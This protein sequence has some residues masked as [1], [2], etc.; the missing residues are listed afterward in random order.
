MPALVGRHNSSNNDDNSD[1]DNN[2]DRI[3]DNAG[4][5]EVIV[6]GRRDAKGWEKIPET[7]IYVGCRI[8]HIHYTPLNGDG[9]F[10]YVRMSDEE[11]KELIN[12][13]DNLRYHRVHKWALLKVGEE[14]YWEWIVV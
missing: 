2:A 9:E 3:K 6:V 7:N 4:D 5:K 13:N 1:H 11:L 14:S 8:D 12:N 10:F